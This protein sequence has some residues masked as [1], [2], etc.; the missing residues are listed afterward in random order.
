MIEKAAW[1][2]ILYCQEVTRTDIHKIIDNNWG[3]VDE[4]YVHQW[5]PTRN[6]LTTPQRYARVAQTW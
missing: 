5:L 6:W 4:A 1:F 3:L 2:D